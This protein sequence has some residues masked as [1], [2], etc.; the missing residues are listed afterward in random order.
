M[1]HAADTRVPYPLDRDPIFDGATDP[2]GIWNRAAKA[3]WMFYTSRRA[4]WATEIFDDGVIYHIYVGFIRGVPKQWA[5]HSLAIRHYTSPDLVNWTFISTLDL[6]SDGV[7]DACVVELPS[8]GYRMWFKDEHAGSR[9]FAADSADLR[10]WHRTGTAVD[11]SSHQGP[12][13][14]RLGGTWWMILGEW[15]GPRV[16]RSEDLI[17]RHLQGRILDEERTGPYLPINSDEEAAH[18]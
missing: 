4:Y 11:V 9:T 10:E 6:E 13:V 16:L 17:H 15:E 3:W 5:G 12:N 7:I 1:T 18:E 8:G 14:F 2:T